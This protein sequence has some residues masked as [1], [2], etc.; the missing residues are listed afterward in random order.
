MRSHILIFVG[1]SHD[2]WTRGNECSQASY[3]TEVENVK[4]ELYY[5]RFQ[6]RPTFRNRVIVLNLTFIVWFLD[7]VV[8]FMLS[9]KLNKVDKT[10]YTC[11]DKVQAIV[12]ICCIKIIKIK[13]LYEILILPV[14]LVSKWNTVNSSRIQLSTRYKRREN[15]ELYII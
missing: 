12:F 2:S 4:N 6:Y 3:T 10:I 13:R 5:S 11:L 14:V 15:I 9:W 1:L 8:I 7:N